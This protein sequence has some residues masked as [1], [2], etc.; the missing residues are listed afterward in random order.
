[1]CRSV[2]A[3]AEHL[4]FWTR[5]DESLRIGRTAV[6]Y[7]D[8]NDGGSLHER[9]QM[10][11]AERQKTERMLRF[12]KHESPQKVVLASAREM[13][14]LRRHARVQAA[15]RAPTRPPPSLSRVGTPSA[16]DREPS[17]RAPPTR[18]M[19]V[20]QRPAP[21]WAEISDYEQ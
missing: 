3:R 5:M 4:E 8:G 7:A 19:R 10:L 11:R 15:R 20:P 12:S 21:A 14:E 17:W 16:L 9:L 18:R 6:V 13:G 2:L 1:M